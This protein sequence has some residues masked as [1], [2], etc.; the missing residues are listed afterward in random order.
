[1]VI[2]P[3]ANSGDGCSVP[4]SGRSP[5]GGNGSLLQYSCLENPMDRRTW[6]ATVH[7][8]AKSDTQQH[9]ADAA[10]MTLNIPSLL[11][12]FNLFWNS[13]DNNV[14]S[15]VTALWLPEAL[16]IFYFCLLS[17]CCSNC[18]NSIGLSSSSQ[19][20]ADHLH[21]TFNPVQHFL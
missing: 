12:F 3:P 1:M 9:T 20:T 13:P 2:N 6:W 5:G 17:L 16:F 14:A 10:I 11:F 4:G 19:T 21:L 8:V 7:G 18:T 15:F